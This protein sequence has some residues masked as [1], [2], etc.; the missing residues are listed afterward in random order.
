MANA[1]KKISVQRGYDLGDYAL[2][3]FGAA[4]GQHA[5]RLGEALGMTTILI[6][7]YA[8]VLSAYGMGLADRRVLREQSLEL[9]LTGEVMPEIQAQMMVL[10]G[11]ASTELKHQGTQDIRGMQV[12]RQLHLRYGGTDSTLVVDFGEAAQMRRQFEQ[13]YQQRFGITLPG[14]ALVVAAIAAEVIGKTATPG[15]GVSL[16]GGSASLG[17]AIAQVPM[18]SGPGAGAGNPRPGH[19]PGGDGNQ[20]GRVWLACN[21]ERSRGFDSDSIHGP[22]IHG[23]ICPGSDCPGSD[24]PGPD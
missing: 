7:P 18:F 23:P 13:Q 24:C 15:Q 12:R 19:Y 6:H 1:I 2:C 5:C 10:V 4:G 9:P 20:C 14:K 11:Q 3:C 21:G 17:E 16:D 22:I 8:G